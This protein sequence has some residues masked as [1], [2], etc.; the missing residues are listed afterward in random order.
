MK[1][2]SSVV[3]T[4]ASSG[5]GR[6]LA[7]EYA[8]RGARLGLIARRGDALDEL[9]KS[10]PTR[11]YC[12]RLD[13]RDAVALSAAAKD[14]NERVGCPDIVIANAGVSAGTS[15]TDPLDSAVFEQILAT[16]LTGMMLTFSPF[17]DEMCRAKRGTLVGIA[18]VAGFRGLPGASAYCA[19]K[20]AAITYLESLRL[21][22][23]NHGVKVVTVC[24]GYVDTPMTA[25]NPYPMPFLMPVDRAA[26]GIAS[27]IARGKRFH[28]LPWQMALF[29]WLLRRLPRPVFDA[30]FAGAPRKPRRISQGKAGRPGGT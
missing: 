9:A 16:N 24:P 25:G 29:G 26:V 15:T 7:V 27:A 21:E 28:V 12:Y 22:L 20:S 14:F 17:I 30:L 8:R 1:A 6:A 3:I 23:R 11:C 10:L 4:G 18:S 13:V 5:L 19:S 2:A